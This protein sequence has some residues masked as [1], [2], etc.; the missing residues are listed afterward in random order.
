MTLV[1][2][3]VLSSLAKIDRLAL[4]DATFDD[5][6]TTPAVLD[7]LHSDSVAGYA[8]VDRIDELKSYNGGWLRIR[9]PTD[10]E[11]ALTDEIVDETLSYTD[12]ECLAVA[13]QRA[14]RLLTDD[15]HLG[16]IAVDRCVAEV[17]DLP[18]FLETC[19]TDGHIETQEELSTLLA[20][21][22][23]EDYYRLSQSAIDRLYDGL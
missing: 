12:A 6:A 21:L 9:S 17:W 3:N 4:L 10:D 2:N 8:F 18:L 14:E 1:D 13:E 5:V 23:T 22:R 11:L 20:D 16:T 7:E 15:A 19:V